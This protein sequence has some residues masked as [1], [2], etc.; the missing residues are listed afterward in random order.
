MDVIHLQK[1][2]AFIA[3]EL[4]EKEKLLKESPNRY[5]YSKDLQRGINMFLAAS[6]EIGLLGEKVFQYADESEFLNQYICKPIRDWFTDW[7]QDNAA[8]LKLEE[9]PFYSYDAFAYRRGKSDVYIA[10]EECMEFMETQES[11]IIEGTDERAL[12]EKIIQFSQDDY[13][14]IRKYI[15][16]HPV[17]NIDDRRKFMSDYADNIDFKD[18]FNI[19]YEQYE[20][21]YVRCHSCGWTMTEGNYGYSCVSEHCLVHS[22]LIDPNTKLDAS[23]EPIYRLKKGI[24]RYF[25]IPGKLELAIA[26]HCEKKKLKYVLWPQKDRYDI[27]IQFDD[28]EVWEIDAKAYRNPLSLRSKIENDGGFPTGNYKFGFFVIPNE[29]TTNKSNYTSVI[30]RTLQNL[31][32]P[33]VKCL[34]LTGMTRRINKKVGELN[35]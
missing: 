2:L 4:L 35:G 9:Q 17:I 6:Y 23:M 33:N 32:Q 1:S 11:N 29:Y 10:S 3:K 20:G 18:A 22:P 27:E 24:M 34:T 5:P 26:E 14:N 28:G 16:E 19:A 30:N 31:N 7:D 12:F 21:T 25:A 15:I 13:C 8:K